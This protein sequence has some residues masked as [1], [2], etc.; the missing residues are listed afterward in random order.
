MASL[1]DISPDELKIFLQ[2]AQSLLELLDEEIVRLEQEADDPSILQEI[3]RVAH[4][5]K[6]SSG[7]LGF[8]EMSSLTHAME[9][10]LDGVRKGQLLVTPELVDALLA[11]LDGLKELKDALA[12][13]VPPTLEVAPIIESLRRAGE[14]GAVP[15]AEVIAGPAGLG[16][17]LAADEE[18]SRRLAAARERGDALH[19]LH[20]RLDPDSEWGAVRCF[21]VLNEIDGLGE[22]IV[23]VPTQS[24]IEAEQVGHT[25]ELL[26]ASDAGPERLH[27]VAAAVMDVIEVDVA[28]WGAD[29]LVAVADAAP[30]EVAAGRSETPR[31]EALQ[32]TVRIDVEQL[33]ALMNV[34][35]ELVIDRTRVSQLS[36][37]LHSRFKDDE[38]VRAL[39]D[40]SQHIQKVVDEL[41]ERMMQVR[42]LPV[43]L[44]FSK[45]P[46]LVRD[47]ARSIGKEVRLALEGEETELDRFVIEKIVPLLVSWTHRWR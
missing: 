9:E 7:M 42:M 39:V 14:A 11:S 46:R 16:E 35:V 19:T 38:Q 13:G 40:T 36:R 17:A 30:T 10:L 27:E 34:G 12:A 26:V 6:G 33:D 15:A 5:L 31:L 24:A 8:E 4:T 1:P 45:F 43:G 22:V 29:A 28:P 32:S 20:C 2:E 25:L 21:Q 37:A 3:F 47:L 41:H 18:A 44:L 23:S